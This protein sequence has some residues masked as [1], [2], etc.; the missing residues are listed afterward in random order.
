[1]LLLACGLSLAADVKL[2]AEVYR[3]AMRHVDER[4]LWPERVDHAAM[5]RAAADR[6]E[7][8]VEWLTV[9]ESGTTA[10]LSSGR[11]HQT[12]Q[13]SGDLPLAL[14]ELES[15]VRA[16]GL[17][18]PQ[19]LD[20]RA[21]L[22]TGALSTLDRHSIALA[23]DNLDRFDERLS[24]TLTGIGVTLR[25]V[26]EHLTIIEVFAG[27]PAELAGLRTDDRL[28]RIDGVS[29]VGMLPSDA[30]DRIRGRAGMPVRIAVLRNESIIE[31]TLTR[32]EVRIPNVTWAEGPRG[33]GVVRIDHFSEQTTANLAEA[34]GRLNASIW[35]K[36]GLIVDLR[37]NTGGSLIQSAKSADLFT[38]SGRI[39]MT[40]GRKGEK[41]A[42]LVREVEAKPG[43]QLYDGPIVVLIDHET[44]SG[45]EILAGALLHLDRAILIGETSFGKGTVQTIYQL[46]PGLKIKLTVAE[47]IL[48]DD[49]RVANVGLVPDLAMYPVDIAESQVEYAELA[50]VR[51]RLA[52]DV[53]LF[54][55]ARM[56]GSN[57]ADEPLEIAAA[58]LESGVTADRASLLGALAALAP[59]LQT[60][61]AS[62][63]AEAMRAQGLDWSPAGDNP[64]DTHATVRLET[65]STPR[66]GEPVTVV[67]HVT[68]EGGALASAAIRLRSV[69]RLWDDLLLPVG[70]VPAGA[71]V[72]GEATVRVAPDAPA[73]VDRVIA[74]LECAGCTSKEVLDTTLAV[75]GGE[76]PVLHVQLR[77][78]DA[79]VAVKVVNRSD[80]LLPGVRASLAFPQV[81]GVEL[82]DAPRE[83]HAIAAGDAMAVTIP[84]AVAEE[85]TSDTIP[86]TLAVRADGFGTFVEWDLELPVDGSTL[87]LAAPELTVKLAKLHRTPGT[88]GLTIVATDA[89]GLRHVTM[90]GGPQR[91]DRSRWEPSVRWDEDKL[92][93]WGNL[94]RRF[95]QSVSVPVAPGTNRYEITAVDKR[96]LRSTNIMYI[97]GEGAPPTDDGVALA[98]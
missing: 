74:Q 55:W 16:A 76:I 7:T 33:T 59:S 39:V 75:E 86:L 23:G 12:V 71:T 43:A 94:D 62:R 26:D 5:F 93:Y 70:A 77:K 31:V 17:D 44:A 2:D 29:T 1:M 96:G 90:S 35:L 58:L 81:S 10:L 97:H 42:G 85:Y 65:R 40:A 45:A 54:P 13:F 9:V 50:R 28:V 67:A 63:L 64:I 47:Y 61:T 69:N 32:A 30:T 24:G 95:S 41:V 98:P 68:N 19:T 51:A 91:V 72:S 53:P 6:I 56:A 82:M 21:E 84:L 57:T 92:A 25:N 14:A 3:S 87:D 4:Y 18:L 11:W 48:D 80:R 73:R 88:T 83:L 66:A 37:G 15:G 60:Q 27:S 52:A 78:V 34:V 89:D 38:D 8:R 46:A 49:A 36:H 20:L 22:L 79:G